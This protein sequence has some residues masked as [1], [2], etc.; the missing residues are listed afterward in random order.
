VGIYFKVLDSTGTAVLDPVALNVKTTAAGGGRVQG[1]FESTSYVNWLYLIA[2]LAAT[3][4]NNTYM[5]TV[6][7]FQPITF[8]IA[9][10]KATSTT[11]LDLTT[12]VSE[13]MLETGAGEPVR[14]RAERPKD[15]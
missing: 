6:Q 13:P 4:G 7:G 10:V 8:T 5:L 2:T 12:Y 1:P 15:R 11:S 14:L 9:G 3:P